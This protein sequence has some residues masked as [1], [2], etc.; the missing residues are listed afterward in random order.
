MYM[1]CQ[2][3]HN[4]ILGI[5]ANNVRLSAHVSIWNNVS[6]GI[7]PIDLVVISQWVIT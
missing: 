7:G 3:F 2:V 5:A 1:V 6:I 4:H